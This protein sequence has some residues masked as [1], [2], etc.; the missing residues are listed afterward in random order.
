M[1][2]DQSLPNDPTHPELKAAKHRANKT[3]DSAVMSATQMDTVGKDAFPFLSLPLEL[4]TEVVNHVSR[5]SD[6]KALR[7][8]SQDLSCI[9]VPRLYYK[10]HLG[11]KTT[12]NRPFRDRIDSLLIQPANLRFVRV[13]SATEL[14]PQEARLMDRLLPLLGQDSLTEFRFG[15]TSAKHFPTALQIQFICTNQKN[16]KYDTLAAHM[17]PALGQLLK[18][19]ES[20]RDSW[21]KSVTQLRMTGLIIRGYEAVR[22]MICWPLKN[23]DLSIL[24]KMQIDGLLVGNSFLSTLNSLF[25]RGSFV[26]LSN[27]CFENMSSKKLTLT[28]MPSLKTLSF[29]TE[30]MSRGS[31]PLI[32]ADDI[33]LSSFYGWAWSEIEIITVLLAQTSGLEFLSID[34]QAAISSSQRTIKD[35]ASGIIRHQQ[36]LRVLNLAE[37]VLQE[38]EYGAWL[39]DKDIVKAIKSCKKLVDLTLT[40]RSDRPPCCYLSLIQSLPDL[41]HLHIYGRYVDNDQ[42]SL[43]S[44][45]ILFK[46]AEQLESIVFKSQ[47]QDF[48]NGTR[49]YLRKASWVRK[50]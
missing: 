11:Y 7:L 12:W 19:H 48:S 40:G 5:Y 6:L 22:S 16:I 18:V 26:N 46:A 45:R 15:T 34:I 10:V 27:L 24:R 50:T 1:R 23:L 31:L 39:W 44:I 32:L 42:W 20:T 41:V 33:K 36:T 2:S 35:L 4:Q 17:V 38:Y 8:V 30:G 49:R 25:V 29:D 43:K 14:G 13:L 21:L 3:L 37:D 9:V 28:N 47:S